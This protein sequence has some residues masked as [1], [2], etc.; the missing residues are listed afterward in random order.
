MRIES[1]HIDGFGVFFDQHI[2]DIPPG[3]CVLFG[4]NEAGKSTL[5]AF[6]KSVLFGFPMGRGTVNRFEPLRGGRYGGSLSLVTDAGER[7]SVRR[8]P[9]PSKAGKA[10]I[11]GH[12]GAIMGEESLSTLLG[13]VTQDLFESVFA[14]RLAELQQL[15][16][17]TTGKVKGVIYSAGTGVAGKSLPQI[18]SQLEKRMEDLFKTGG[19]KPLINQILRELRDTS[20]RLREIGD[21]ATNYSE[22]HSECLGITGRISS[23]ERERKEKALESERLKT[24]LQAW[25]YWTERETKRTEIEAMGEVRAFPA[26]GVAELEKLK[27]SLSQAKQDHADRERKLQHLT[28]ERD[29]IEVRD[30]IIGEADRIE[31]LQQGRVSYDDAARDLP[32]TEQELEDKSKRLQRALQALGPEWDREKLLTIDASIAKREGIRDWQKAMDEAREKERLA[33]H[34][35]ESAEQAVREASREVDDLKERISSSP[36][37]EEKEEC[38]LV[39][40]L[41]SLD[42]ARALLAEGMRLQGRLKGLEE[43]KED[44]SAEISARTPDMDTRHPDFLLHLSYSFPI[45]GVIAALLPIVK[46]H[47]AAITIGLAG[48]A[49]GLIALY[50]RRK[51]KADSSRVQGVELLKARLED[52]SNQ[53]SALRAQYE[54]LHANMRKILD[55]CEVNGEASEDALRQE[56]ARLMRELDLL[57]IW[58]QAE[59]DLRKAQKRFKEASDALEAA[60]SSNSDAANRLRTIESQWS[61]WLDSASLPRGLSPAG[62]LDVFSQIDTCREIDDGM[63]SL[64]DRIEQMLSKVQDYEQRIRAVL[65]AAGMAHP[66]EPV[67]GALDI[68]A[69][70]LKREIE[71]RSRREMLGESAK[72]LKEEM[73][74]LSHRTISLEE[75]IRRLLESVGASDESEYLDMAVKY[76][77]WQEL[78]ADL[79]RANRALERIS[80]PDRF[81]SFLDSM[82][83]SVRE[84]L[85]VESGLFD[86]QLEEFDEQLKDAIDRRGSL[87]KELE[88]LE[89][90]EESSELR[91]KEQEYRAQLMQ[92]AE[93]WSALR[94]AQEV[95]YQAQSIYER[96]RQPEVIREASGIFNTITAGRYAGIVKPLSEETFD[97]RSSDDRRFG[98]EKLSQGTREQLLLAVRLGLVREFGKRQERM[99]LIMDDVLV[100]FD[101]GRARSTANALYDL[102]EEHQVLLFTCHR[103]T[104]DIILEVSPKIRIFTL[105][106]GV[107]GGS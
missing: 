55:N 1:V 93:Q 95:L 2:N 52:V 14:F 18:H 35:V 102:S 41:S 9:A 71:N 96:E 30:A 39:D 23:L 82:R 99:P 43:R 83:G 74:S 89:S 42:K 24:K 34:R 12:Y 29:A 100:N 60:L 87:K 106:D 19:S 44:L 101:R 63:N 26:N 68:L 8:E 107:T 77:R 80:G 81:Q 56:Q 16:S 65:R 75:G 28:E 86:E 91:L 3:L 25:D 90:E 13:S 22:L 38:V 76:Q 32:I 57:R 11:E 37:P 47:T 33:G 78:A 69:R 20:G 10:T 53:E 105:C 104:V 70:N 6:I 58:K 92:L 15:E 103:E 67:G 7:Y 51:R 40:R 94:I 62:A 73:D 45:L 88:L 46:S 98:I 36:E 85:K 31:R 84:E 61:D 66:D 27:E 48:L 5:L 17:L 79:E 72:E 97:A 64:K 59:N 54:Q 4:D 21:A 50:A 49:V